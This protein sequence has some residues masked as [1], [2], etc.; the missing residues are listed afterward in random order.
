MYAAGFLSYEAAPAFDAVFRVHE[1]NAFPLAWFGL[2]ERPEVTESLPPSQGATSAMGELIPSVSREA[3]ENAIRRIREYIA[4]GD[5]YQIN[6]T[7]RLRAAFSGDTW[8]FFR[9]LIR[10]QQAE[11]GAYLD[12]GRYVICSASPE[13]FF[14]LEG[15]CLTARPM[16]G[17]AP[18]G[19]MLDDDRRQA[20]WLHASEKNRAEN[21]MILDMIRNDM[22]RIAAPGSVEVHDMFKVERYPTLWQMTST[23]VSKTDVPV[24]EIL[25]SLFPCA[26]I[27]GAPKPRAVEII[28]ELETT[29]RRIYTGCIG[30]MEPSRRARFN[31]AIRTVLIDREAGQAEYGIGGGI[32]WDSNSDDEYAECMLKARILTEKRPEFSLLETMLWTPEEGYFLLEYHVKRLGDSAEYFGYPFHRGRILDELMARVGN[33]PGGR[34]KVRLLVTAEGAVTIEATQLADT[35]ESEPVVLKQ[36]P[37]SVDT[38]NPFLYHK[39][40]NRTIYETAKSSCPDCDDVV[41]WNE[42]GEITET[43]IANIVARIDGKLFTPPVQSGLLPGTFRA[44]LLYRGDVR[45]GL[46]TVDDFKRCEDIFVVNSVRRWRRAVMTG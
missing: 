43:G 12:T 21:V 40:T 17:T 18:R 4:A 19:L 26:S 16:K 28:N 45:E 24:G 10:A 35:G 3:Y 32:V 22:G 30:F 11:H 38:A 44:W 13:L 1:E 25:R 36:A 29:P 41:L 15:D 31:V 20:E 37:F 2:Y 9:E 27:T 5:T 34:Y 7:F 23:A 46:I 6:Y 14:H 42:R 8:H 33:L 39:T